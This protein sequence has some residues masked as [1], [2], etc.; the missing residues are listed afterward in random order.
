MLTS[1]Y[2]SSISFP[3]LLYSYA[4]AAGQAQFLY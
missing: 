1:V 3:H 4:A 2:S